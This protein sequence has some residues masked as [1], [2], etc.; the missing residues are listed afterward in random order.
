MP[1]SINDTSFEEIFLQPNLYFEYFLSRVLL[2]TG[3][4]F[5]VLFFK[6]E[7][8][9]VKGSGFFR[10]WKSGWNRLQLISYL[11]VFLGVGFAF[12]KTSQ[13]CSC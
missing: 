8:E 9:H 2:L 10:Y 7:L 3:I 11:M 4:V 13:H 6:S 1:D 12:L 5:N